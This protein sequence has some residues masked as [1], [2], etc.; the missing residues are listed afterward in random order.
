MF[1]MA[2]Y[3]AVQVYLPNEKFWRLWKL[4]K[5]IMKEQGYH[6]VKRSGMWIVLRYT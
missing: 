3:D 6:V 5:Y 1:G 4:N 2:E